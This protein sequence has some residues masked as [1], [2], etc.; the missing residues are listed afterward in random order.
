MSES[1]Q[2]PELRSDYPPSDCGAWTLEGYDT[3]EGEPYPLPGEYRTKAEARQAAQR[4]LVELEQS[5]P[6]SFSGGQRADGIQDRVYIIH[7]DGHKE[8]FLG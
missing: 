6:S 4:R 1:Q 5:Q 7:P 3:Y 8:R 2:S